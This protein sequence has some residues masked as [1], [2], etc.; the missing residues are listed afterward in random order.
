MSPSASKPDLFTHPPKPV[1]IAAIEREL[2]QLWKHPE[3]SETNRPEVIRACMSNLIVHCS[4]QDQAN[5]V[6]EELDEIVRLHPS[7]VLLLVGEAGTGAGTIEAYVSAHC[8][9]AGDHGRVCS[10]HVTVHASGDAIPRLPSTA[11]SLLIGDLPTSLWWASHEAPPLGGPLFDELEAMTDQVVYSSL[12]WTDPKQGTLATTRWARE[13]VSAHMRV[14]DLAWRRLKP[15]RSLIGQ[16]LD[17]VALPGALDALDRVTIEHGSHSLPQACLLVGWLASRLGWQ[18]AGAAFRKGDELAWR[19]QSA[20]NPVEVRTKRIDDGDPE[21]RDVVLSW[22]SDAT[23]ATMRF[24]SS[25]PGKLS[26]TCDGI[27]CQP[28]VLL[29]PHQS[30]ANLVGLQLQDRDPD[31]LFMESLAMSGRMAE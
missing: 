16:S 12:S 24:S 14:A 21:V 27:C 8:H 6:T 29:A 1:G 5:L 19:F 3:S 18:P 13:A 9:L 22:T 30:R 17:P 26:V 15:W 31:P 25:S 20:T 2:A 11:R 10:E 4:S 23:R 7:R 28:R